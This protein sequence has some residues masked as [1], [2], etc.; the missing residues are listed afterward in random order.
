M[1]VGQFLLC[2]EF[3]SFQKKQNIIN[4]DFDGEIYF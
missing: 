4:G 2:E 3:R 1:N